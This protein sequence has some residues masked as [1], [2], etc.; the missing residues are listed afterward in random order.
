MADSKLWYRSNY[1]SMVAS[2]AVLA[3][4]TDWW[5]D[6]WLA[7]IS[8]RNDRLAMIFASMCLSL[9]TSWL[10]RVIGYSII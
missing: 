9:A 8:R 5:L 7:G 4:L 10:P 6:G 3:H 1:Y 2:T